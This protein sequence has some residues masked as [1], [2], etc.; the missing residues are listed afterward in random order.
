MP[1]QGQ[2]IPEYTVPH[3]MTY[4]ND[5]TEFSEDKPVVGDNRAKTFYVFTSDKG[6]DN[7]FVDMESDIEYVNEFGAPNFKRHGQAALMPYVSLNTGNVKVK[8]MRIMPDDATY[9]NVALVVS[10]KINPVAP[11]AEDVVTKGTLDLKFST[12]YHPSV[13]DSEEIAALSDA[14]TTED[15][16]LA[17]FVNKHVFTLYSLGRGKYGNDYRFR[18]AAAPLADR[19]NKFKNHRLEILTSENGLVTKEFFS[20]VMATNAVYR[21][22]SAH[23]GDLIDDPDTGSKSIGMYMNEDVMD[24]LFEMY[25]KV[26]PDNPYTPE[27]FDIFLGETLQGKGKLPGLNILIEG[28]NVVDVTSIEGLSFAGGDDGSFDFDAPASLEREEAIKQR[29]ID[30]FSGKIDVSILSRRRVP[31][32][33]VLDAN[34]PLEVKQSIANLVIKRNDAV[35]YID[36]GIINTTSECLNWS[37]DMLDVIDSREIVKEGT[38]YKVKDPFT[39][40]TIPVTITYFYAMDIPRHFIEKG[41]HDPYAASKAKLYGHIK[42]SVRPIID[43]DELALKNE[44]YEN[45]VNVFECTGENQFQRVSCLTSQLIWSDLS[46]ESNMHTLF[47]IKRTLEDYI[48]TQAYNLVEEDDRRQLT[49]A[50]TRLFENEIGVTI[51]SLD[52]SFNMTPYEEERS[53]VHA[54]VSVI[55]KTIGKRYTIE[56]DINKRV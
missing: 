3:Y 47:R 22:K 11:L 18:I 17:G 38:S 56:M 53:I 8:C 13:S 20:G 27:T 49:E 55:F 29:F 28:E 15:P 9:A 10:A 26:Y 36:G 31:A 44:I 23:L 16:D 41:R 54:Y 14:L 12:V 43:A 40:K 51:R 52:V 50:A 1:R 39:R 48:S 6:R 2:I 45:R 5:Y 25:K 21:K 4:I 19:D 32:D 37:H 24:E 7:Q 46:E 42:N 33:F 34:F 35:G 30:A